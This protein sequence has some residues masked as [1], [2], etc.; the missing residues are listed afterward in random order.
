MNE[1]LA[2]FGVG[3]MGGLTPGPLHSLI[4][5]TALKRGV[6]PALRLAFAPLFSDAPPVLVSLWIA[7][8]MSDGVA[9][10]LAVLGGLFLI[11]LAIQ[12]LRA[13][14]FEEVDIE[15]ADEPMKDYFRGAIVNILNPNPWLFWLG[16][17]A[18]LL[19]R[20]WAEGVGFG[21][22]WLVVFYTGLIGVKVGFAVIVGRTRDHLPERALK[23]SIMVS[24][25]LML[26]VGCWLVFRGVTGQI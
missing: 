18:P 10:T 21:V 12:A 13:D 3:V 16:V 23:G 1:L 6:R 19:R 22:L 5:T 20:V 7:A 11:G 4:V 14:H 25:V 9:R 15:V 24:T 26:A 2:A 8:T 17:G